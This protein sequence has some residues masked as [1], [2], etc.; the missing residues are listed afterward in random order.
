VTSTEETRAYR[1]TVATGMVD[2]GDLPG[3]SGQPAIAYGISRDGTTIVGR[4]G[5]TGSTNYDAFRWT[6]GTG[7]TDLGFPLGPNFIIAEARAVNGD[8]SVVV[9]DSDSAPVDCFPCF[10]VTPHPF[11]W[12]AAAGMVDLGNLPGSTNGGFATAVS[13]DGSIVMGDAYDAN[14]TDSQTAHPRAFRWTA[15]TGMVDLGDLPGVTPGSVGY[16]INGVSANGAIAVGTGLSAIRWTQATGLQD[17]RTLLVAAGVD[18]TG[19]T[20]QNAIAI[21]SDGQFIVGTASIGVCSGTRTY[22]ARYI[23]A[24]VTQPAGTPSSS[25][26]IAAGSE[27]PLIGSSSGASLTLVAAVLPLS[28][29]VTL[30]GTPATAFAT[31]ID[32]GPGDATGCSIAPATTVPASFVYQT[33]DPTTN[34]VTGIVNTPVNIAQGA[35]QSFVVAFT[36]S[37]EFAPTDVAFT[38]TCANA[39]PVTS[40]T[41][42]N[43]INLSAS[44]P[45][46][47]DVVAL[48]ASG[49]PGFVDIPGATGTGAFAVATVNVG[50]DATIT[51]AA[52]TG[53]ANLPVTLTLCQTDPTSGAC[54]ATP[55][56]SVTTDIQPNATPT[57][58][59]FV[60]GSAA[61]ANLSG[62]NRVFVTFT[63]GGGVL[64][65]ETSVA[66]RTH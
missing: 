28:R 64:R 19:I 47:P 63:D 2:L 61:V 32:A 33:T 22:I 5:I 15:A 10:A 56:T 31:I 41:G 51:A 1:W 25:Q 18:M 38:F 49:D 42:V 11:R 3:Q 66:V 50:A 8:G 55:A 43:T 53:T 17:L 20:L 39:T 4:S 21:S 7:M 57:F 37:A 65:G 46:A 45:R 13:D 34:A 60:T 24:A 26:T 58:G 36:P 30:C 16:A 35:A 27:A 52:N 12:T 29:S 23:D 62:I 44:V 59:I 6:A 54:L 40:I 48:A 14:D 9:G